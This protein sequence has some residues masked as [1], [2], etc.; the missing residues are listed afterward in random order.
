MRVKHKLILSAVSVLLL[1]LLAGCGSNSTSPGNSDAVQPNLTDVFGGYKATDEAPA[2][3]DPTLQSMDGGEAANDDMGHPQTL[4]SLSHLPGLNVYSVRILWGHLDYDSSETQTTDWTGSLTLLHGAIVSYRLIG[5][6][7]GDHIVRPRT[8]ARE[9]SFV[10][11]TK[12]YYDG[13]L[14]YIFDPA[15]SDSAGGNTLTFATAPFSKTFTIDELDSV[16][17]IDN[18]GN[19][20][21]SAVSGAHH[22]WALKPS[23]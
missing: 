14:F 20:E 8:S 10:S 15:N 9:L 11:H 23:A 2:F 3:G 19:N 16:D 17:E 6:E 22:N 21:G 5:F 7:E 13:I 18:A 4:D 1:M 12:P